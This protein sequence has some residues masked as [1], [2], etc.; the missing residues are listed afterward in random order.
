VSTAEVEAAV[1]GF[2][3]TDPAFIADPYPALAALRAVTPLFRHP[4]SRLWFVT[5]FGDV[6]DRLRDPR[7]G[8]VR[9]GDMGRDARWTSF[10]SVEHWSLLDLEPPDHTRI[11]SLV[12]KAFTAKAVAS[13]RPV[14]E[15]LIVDLV[16]GLVAG[17]E[18]ELL[19]DV[20]QP[21]SIGVI[22]SLLGVPHDDAR[23]LLEW[24]HAMV[25]MY[26]LATLEAQ[27]VAA[28]QAAAEFDGYVR[29]LITDR[30]QRLGDDL[31]SGLVQAENDSRLSDGEIVST[32]I[33]LLNAG[34]EATVNTLGNG[35]VAFARHPDEWRRVVAGEVPAK[36]AVEE[37]L[38]WDPPLQLF[39]RWVL[40]DGVEVGGQEIPVGEKIGFLFGSA[41]RDPDR[42]GDADRFDAGR[43]DAKHIGFGGGI[44]YC[45]GAPLARLE[46]EVAVA[47]LARRLPVLELTVP[48]RRTGA[49][50]IRGFQSVPLAN[51]HQR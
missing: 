12:S 50:V 2:D 41:N 34:H 14:A 47:A 33:L 26:E 4:H 43:G 9:D 17:E 11:R 22:C 20:A 23:M 28:D 10:W 44:H 49:F 40:T 16:D 42:F 3:V 48:P 21:Y 35:M 13:M 27:A 24:S 37:M 1:A 15:T 45:L 30:R 31:L 39:E 32:V 29:A 8:R 19:G 46:L 25:K 38:R 5:R 7:L 51:P 6:H 18:V 36:V